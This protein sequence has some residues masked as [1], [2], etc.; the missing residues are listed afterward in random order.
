MTSADNVL[1]QIETGEVLTIASRSSLREAEELVEALQKDWPGKYMIQP[2]G[3]GP[4]D[5]AAT[6]LTGG[7]RTATCR[8]E[9]V[10]RFTVP[11]P[12]FAYRN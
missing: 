12:S 2:A 3:S 5:S 10:R 9:D 7:D 11:L 6:R 8:D 4:L 1:R